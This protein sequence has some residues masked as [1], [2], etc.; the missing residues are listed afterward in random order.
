MLPNPL[1]AAA[2]GIFHVLLQV[3]KYDVSSNGTVGG[4]EVPTA[5]KPLPLIALFELRERALHLVGRA[6][7]HQPD[8]VTYSQ[9]RRH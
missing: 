7:F 9:F 1:T 2:G 8:Q 5:P 3:L 4:R 6:A